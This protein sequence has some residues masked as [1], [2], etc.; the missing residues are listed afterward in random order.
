M[1]IVRA[2]RR[3]I[4]RVAVRMGLEMEMAMHQIWAHCQRPH[5][6]Y[7]IQHQ[8]STFHFHIGQS[9]KDD[10]ICSLFLY[11]EQFFF[12]LNQNLNENKTKMASFCMYDFV[13]FAL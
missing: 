11:V 10:G 1:A 8:V 5:R 9:I 4:H 6:V 3:H 7:L 2:H 13:R 12:F